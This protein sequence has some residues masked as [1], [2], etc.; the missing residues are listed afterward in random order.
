M[1]CLRRHSVVL[2]EM[3]GARPGSSEPGRSSPADMSV[4]IRVFIVLV[5]GYAGAVAAGAQ[6]SDIPDPHQTAQE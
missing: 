4:I 6:F 2:P 3:S 5:C 1:S